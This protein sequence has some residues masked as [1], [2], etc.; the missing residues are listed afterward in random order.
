MNDLPSIKEFDKALTEL[1]EKQCDAAKSSAVIGNK[2]RKITANDALAEYLQSL[3]NYMS[4]RMVP[5][6]SA[7]NINNNYGQL[8]EFGRITGFLDGGFIMKTG[9]KGILFYERGLSVKVSA[10]ESPVNIT[11]E[12][13]CCS[14]IKKTEENISEEHKLSLVRDDVILIYATG[15]IFNRLMDIRSTLINSCYAA[16]NVFCRQYRKLLDDMYA[17]AIEGNFS[18]ALKIYRYLCEYVSCDSRVSHRVPISVET[19][20]LMLCHRFDDASSKAS[21]YGMI[22]WQQLA[23][24]KKDEYYR[25][26]SRHFYIEAVRHYN[27]RECEECIESVCRSIEIYPT[28]ENYTLYYK[29]VNTFAAKSNMFLHKETDGIIN[30]LQ[31][32]AGIQK[33]AIEQN[34]DIIEA[35]KLKQLKFTAYLRELMIDRIKNDDMAFFRNDT[36]GIKTYRDKY[37]MNALSYAA[38]YRKYSMLNEMMQIMPNNVTRNIIGHNPIDICLFSGLNIYEY[39]SFA[40]NYNAEYCELKRSALYQPNEDDETEAKYN[41]S[42][43]SIGDNK[44]I[45]KYY[46]ESADNMWQP[47]LD[48][49]KKGMSPIPGFA[50]EEKLSADYKESTEY[51]KIV[52]EKRAEFIDEYVK[53]HYTPKD[54]FETTLQYNERQKKLNTEAEKAFLKNSE[55][56]MSEYEEKLRIAAARRKMCVELSYVYLF[57]YFSGKAYIGMYDADEQIFS[58][59]WNSIETNL[60]VPLSEARQFKEAYAENGFPFEVERITVDDDLSVTAYCIIRYKNREYQMKLVKQF[61]GEVLSNENE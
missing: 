55:R 7:F 36:Y 21:M 53:K 19:A 41:P 8:K 38:L 2:S 17:Y 56:I 29:T 54:E 26:L 45:R 43:L 33:A 31:S 40:G 51:K 50:I 32:A 11:Y 20:L 24:R 60:S 44:Q 61:K 15:R 52:E 13:L 1:L 14:V 5:A 27:K 49:V 18:D 12:E 59:R 4:W 47:V 10:K 39:D 42:Q 28:L 58:V 35:L 37:G 3:D 57:S 46:T 30:S 23:N 16:E 22:D 34:K 9:K 25:I 48:Y 6:H